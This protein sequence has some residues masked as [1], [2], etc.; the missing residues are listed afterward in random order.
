MF[1]DQN[2]GETEI[3][4]SLQLAIEIIFKNQILMVVLSKA[5]FDGNSSIILNKVNSG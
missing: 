5:S 3:Q 4:A 1:T 2:P